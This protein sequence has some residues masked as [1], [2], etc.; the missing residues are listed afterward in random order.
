MRYA[1]G[2][3][4]LVIAALPFAAILTPRGDTSPPSAAPSTEETIA[5]LSPHRREVRLEY[6]RG[7][8]DWMM[9]HHQRRASVRWLDVGGTSKLLKELES[10]FATAPDNP[11]VDLLFGGGVDPY[12]RAAR[13]NW[14]ER[15][16][17]PSESLADIPP[18][19]AGAPVFDPNGLW[20]GV[21]L[22]GFGI[23]YNAPL[24]KRLKLSPPENWEDL[25]RP[26][27]FTWVGSGDPRSSGSVHM[28]YEIILQAYGFEK[29]W[30]LI[31]RI[32]GN[33]RN[34]G[35]AG[36]TVPR[37]VASGDIAAGMVIDQY[38]NTIVQTVGS[39]SAVFV[40]PRRTTMIGPDAIGL[41][42]GSRHREL[43][44]LFVEFAL[45]PAG[46][47]ILYQPAGV[48]G[49]KH[50]LYRMPVARS[51][52]RDASAPGPDPYS[53]PAALQFD[54]GKG[55]RR[56]NV[57]N[58]LMGVWL[59]D[60]HA[61]L[62]AAW[63][64]TIESGCPPDRLALLCAPPLDEKELETMAEAWKDPRRKQDITRSWARAAH[65]RYSR[66]AR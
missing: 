39:D 46:Q 61:E 45:S 24:I 50:S 53:F 60:A 59:I 31:T 41:I 2:I 34:F 37:E 9:K 32:C 55:A 19:C 58:D 6:S 52:Y 23:L 43:A 27:Y 5:I 20:Y 14:L 13:E 17:V 25:G 56:W 11:G 22:S 21:A 8:S 26:E 15:L 65:D 10:R 40:L 30:A 29:G 51:A 4:F 35:E 42:R 12:L 16:D 54:S 66:L 33:V 64:R 7:F 3:L 28:C 1:A 47:R 36:G 44:R 18:A 38:A 48:N 49:Q 62:C 63:K 57:V